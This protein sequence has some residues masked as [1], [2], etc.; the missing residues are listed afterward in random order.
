MD[1]AQAWV[2]AMTKAGHRF[3]YYA[4]PRCEGR[5]AALIPPEDRVYDS[6]VICPHCAHSHFKTAF[7]DGSVQATFPDDELL[8]ELAEGRA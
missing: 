8:G 6:I 1:A 3:S 4:C 5:N 7:A 2:D